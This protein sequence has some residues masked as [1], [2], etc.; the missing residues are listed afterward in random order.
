M[1]PWHKKDRGTALGL[2][3]IFVTILGVWLGSALL[4]T[5]ISNTGVNQLDLQNKNSNQIATATAT[6]LQQLAA[7]STKG[8]GS[9]NST[10]QPNC[11]LPTS[12]ATASGAVQVTCTPVTNNPLTDCTYTVSQLNGTGTTT[13]NAPCGASPTPTPTGTGSPSPTPT[14][15]TTLIPSPTPTPCGATDTCAGSGYT[16]SITY[17]PNT[18]SVPTGI[19]PTSTATYTQASSTATN[20]GV[21]LTPNTFAGPCMQF[22]GWNTAA[23]GSGTAYADGAPVTLSSNWTA[24]LYA[25]WL[26]CPGAPTI[27]TATKISSTSISVTFT[28]P[29]K[30]GG[31]AITSYTAI[32]SPENEMASI[33]QSGSGTITVSGLTNGQQYTLQVYASNAIGNSARSLASNSVATSNNDPGNNTSPT[34]APSGVSAVL[35]GATG[36]NVSFTG[37]PWW[38]NGGSSITNYYAISTPGNIVGSVSG[39][40]S[41]LTGGTSGTIPVSG[42]SA[43]TTYTFT[44]Y[45]KNGVG[46]SSFSSPSNS[47]TTPITGTAYTVNYFTNTTCA[48][49]TVTTITGNGSS[50]PIQSAAALGITYSGYT[51]AGWTG[52]KTATT[53]A[54]G[55]AACGASSPT[56]YPVG[57]PVSNATST[58]LYLYAVWTAGG[59]GGTVP[60]ITT[61]SDLDNDIHIHAGKHG[62]W[63]IKALNVLMKKGIIRIFSNNGRYRDTDCSS[64][65]THWHHHLHFRF[66]RGEHDFDSDDKLDIDSKSGTNGWDT[67]FDNDSSDAT[68]Q[69]SNNRL[70]GCTYTK[71]PTSSNYWSGAQ[72]VFSGKSSILNEGGTFNI[73]GPNTTTGKKYAITSY[74]QSQINACASLNGSASKCPSVHSGTDPLYQATSTGT[75]STPKSSVWGTVYSADTSI[76]VSQ[77]SS[78]QHQIAGGIVSGSATV[79]CTSGSACQFPV[80]SGNTTGRVLKITIVCSSGVRSEHL[81][82][83]NDGSGSTPGSKFTVTNTGS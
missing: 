28:A 59:N 56:A 81:I 58:T 41:N 9:S 10:N 35:S 76:A 16:Y 53:S 22:T 54:L 44:V 67:K 15:S 34:A 23:D 7:D 20:L 65:T 57:T 66:D 75:N 6:V 1:I 47:I 3:L 69:F 31:S 50:I 39:S 46:N 36:A 60:P 19:S 8:S 52:G 83:I 55:S 24:T 45:A 78:Y 14:P 21:N 68:A 40:Y 80:N 70:V 30:N 4:L 61:C 13:T 12:V 25:Q 48:D 2:V 38:S 71:A 74:S 51:F 26:T 5:Q 79:D 77:G 27:G 32:T 49:A 82:Y 37:I 17:N 18:A 62:G 42:L 73:C 29:T 72:L 33:S 63:F 43:G 64:D 11:N